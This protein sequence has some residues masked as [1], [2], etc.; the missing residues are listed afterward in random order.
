MPAWCDLLQ[1]VSGLLLVLFMWAHMLLVSSILLGE[2]A[3][4]T[5]TRFL[6]GYYIFGRSVTGIVTAAAVLVLVLLLFHAALALRKLPA[7]WMQYQRLSRHRHDLRHADTTWWLVQAWS[8]LVILFLGTAH[9]VLMMTHPGEIGPYASADRAWSQGLWLLDLP[10]LLAVEFHGGIGL[11]RLAMKWGWFI[12][13]DP[14]RN[15]ARLKAYIGLLIVFLL[16]LGG[17]T[18]AAYMKIGHAHA[19][20]A[21]ERYAPPRVEVQVL[22]P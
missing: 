7:S 22:R 19:D 15:R 8:G 20:R 6:E 9:L 14:L 1:G 12:T 21:G 10:L 13:D 4:Y 16:L 2:Q 18:L 5:V 3:M 11:Y 17:L